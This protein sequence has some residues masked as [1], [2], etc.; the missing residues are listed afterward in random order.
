MTDQMSELGQWATNAAFS[1][2]SPWA[3]ALDGIIPLNPIERPTQLPSLP[4]LQLLQLRSCG[5]R[6]HWAGQ[7]TKGLRDPVVW[8]LPVL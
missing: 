2:S 4:P 7:G 5:R 3:V 8:N 1:E 6:R